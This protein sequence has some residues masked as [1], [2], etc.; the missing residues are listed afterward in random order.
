MPAMPKVTHHYEYT[1]DEGTRTR[2]EIQLANGKWVADAHIDPETVGACN[3]KQDA[4]SA[5]AQALRMLAD[6]ISRDENE[7]TGKVE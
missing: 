4:R 5:L 2:A 7:N 3:S 6:E 1:I